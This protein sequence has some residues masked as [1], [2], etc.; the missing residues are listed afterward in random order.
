MTIINPKV[1]F[2]HQNQFLNLVRL[3]TLGISGKFFVTICQLTLQF[4]TIRKQGLM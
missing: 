2:Y 3:G 1:G 4:I